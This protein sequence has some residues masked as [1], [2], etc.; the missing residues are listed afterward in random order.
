MT[1]ELNTP[2]SSP[3]GLHNGGFRP[4][5][6]RQNAFAQWAGPLSPTLTA[7]SI[8]EESEV[9]FSDHDDGASST[10]S[11]S[12]S[13]PRFEPP[14]TPKGH[15]LENSRSLLWGHHFSNHARAASTGAAAAVGLGLGLGQL[16]AGERAYD[17]NDDP[18][19]SRE[20]E[21]K[22]GKVVSR[23]LVYL[24]FLCSRADPHP[25][26]CPPPT[27]SDRRRRSPRSSSPRRGPRSAS[28]A[29]RALRCTLSAASSRSCASSALAD[30]CAPCTRCS[31]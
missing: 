26:L 8:D 28:R 7:R 4:F 5:H 16:D 10:A 9:G 12:P 1:A 2:P 29:G 22:A 25:V 14:T 13:P 6:F 19:E 20:R 21:R 27:S 31:R 11:R 3:A 18:F 23:P 24:V 30:A 17:L 15:P